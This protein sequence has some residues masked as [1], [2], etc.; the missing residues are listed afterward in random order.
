MFQS[1]YVQQ[2]TV[3]N[4]YSYCLPFSSDPHMFFKFDERQEAHRRQQALIISSSQTYII[5]YKIHPRE[6]ATVNLKTEINQPVVSSQ[7]TDVYVQNTVVSS[8]KTMMY[9]YTILLCC[10]HDHCTG[11][12]RVCLAVVGS[13]GSQFCPTDPWKPDKRLKAGIRRCVLCFF[14]LIVHCAIKK[15]KQTI[16]M[17]QKM[18]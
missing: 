7:K 6:E 11:W 17:Q 4:K 3:Q 14:R 18:L 15:D 1:Y 5:N 2:L 9:M 10:T 12:S 16:K 13:V 8:Q